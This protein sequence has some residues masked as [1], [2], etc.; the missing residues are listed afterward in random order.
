MA[1]D[2]FLAWHFVCICVCVW[3]VLV[4]LARSGTVCSHIYVL[5]D[6]SFHDGGH[7]ASFSRL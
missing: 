5:Y 4:C 7:L 1:F 6:F 3:D 2:A